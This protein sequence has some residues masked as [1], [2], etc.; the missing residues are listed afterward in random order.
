MSFLKKVVRILPSSIRYNVYLK[1]YYS[2]FFHRAYNIAERET[3]KELFYLERLSTEEVKRYQEKCLIEFLNNAFREVPYY[4]KL[5]EEK[6]DK[7]ITIESFKDIPILSKEDI[8]NNLESLINT[9]MGLASLEV[10]NTGGSTGCPLE[11]YCDDIAG[12]KDNAHHW[13]L[14]S[15]M[16]YEKVDVI[17]SCGGHEISYSKRKNN[18][19]WKKNHKSSVWGQLSFSVLYLTE[20][21]IA[22]YVKKLLQVRPSILRGYPSFFD[23]LATYIVDN[24]IKVDFFIKGVNLTAEM[25][26]TSQRENIEKAF[27][28]KVYFEYGHTEISAYCFTQDDSYIY[29][30]SPCYG[31]LEVLNQNDEPVKCG[32]VGRI[33]STGFNNV[34]M[35][36][37]RYDTGDLCQLIDRNGGV[38]RFSKIMGR[39][40]DYIV[41][42]SG[43]KLYLTALIFG[44]HLHAFKNIIQWQMVQNSVGVVVLKIVKGYDYSHEDENEIR[45]NFHN[46]AMLIVDFIYVESIPLTQRGKHLFL[47]QNIKEG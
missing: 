15:K 18:V 19:F 41:T 27:C 40:Q 16:G 32:E 42:E 34:G 38:I 13:Y 30:S 14:Y 3:F 46:V 29:Q 8:R 5:F 10:R 2:K 35:P 31:Y 21:N 36:F 1:Y 26:S 9:S 4:Q 23:R 24:K 45:D 20:E 37:I 7:S 44:Q 28:T 17:V 6:T 22:V 12:A 33:I 11:F 25:C 43:D 39:N 47:I